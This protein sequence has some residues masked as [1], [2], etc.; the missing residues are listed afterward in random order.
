MN[1]KLAVLLSGILLTVPVSHA[2]DVS[3]DESGNLITGTSNSAGNLEVTGS[4]GEDSIIGFASG[5]GAAGVYGENMTG[6]STNYGI[7]GNDQYGVYGNSSS[8]FAGFFQGNMRVT[9]TFTVDGSVTGPF[10]GDVTAINAG[11]GLTG[12][13]TGGDISI[14]T[15]TTYIQRRVSSACTVGS[16]I[17]AINQDGTVLC[18]TDDGITTESDPKVGSVLNDSVPKWNGTSLVDGTIYDNGNVGIGN[19]TPSEKLTVNGNINASGQVQ[20]D[21]TTGLSPLQVASTTMVNN[22]NC[23]MIAGNTLSG[24]DSRYGQSAP[25]Q[26]PRLNTITTVDSD[27]NTGRFTSITIGTDGLPVIAY[28]S[29]GAGFDLIVLKCGN[30]SCSA[31]NTLTTVDSAGNV[32]QYASITIGTDGLPVISYQDASNEDLKIVKCGDAVCS[33]GN[34]ISVVDSPGAVGYNTS[35]TTGIDGLPIV[36]YWDLTNGY[37]KVLK[38]GNGAC[39]SGNTIT[40]VDNIG[41]GGDYN[42]VAIGTDGLPVIAYYDSTNGDLKVLKCGDAACSSGNTITTVDSTGDT[43]YFAS[44]TVGTDGLP[45]MTYYDITNGDLKVLKCGNAACSSGNTVTTVD[46]DNDSGRHTAIT[47]GDDGLPVIS[48]QYYTGADLKVL[49]CGNAACSA[50][51]TITTIDS[52]GLIG[53]FT[54]ITTGTDGLPV[55]SYHDDTN[56]DLKVVKCANPFC[57]NNWIRR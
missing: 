42:P 57:L 40:V 31:G 50:G 1:W 35:I 47:I 11:A 25:L 4:S 36:T 51:N 55:I 22:L 14:G 19:A 48:Y 12:G 33:A 54:S 7:L 30:A 28:F 3:V 29:P 6:G 39:S 32:G 44:L 37:L 52:A 26:N 24:L 13:G 56:S 34:I 18:E 23:E 2:Q 46:S 15:D 5:T 41:P 27:G 16:S 43:G 38:C 10:I 8:G 53:R 21:V 49:K 17:R 20:S 9:G 45:V